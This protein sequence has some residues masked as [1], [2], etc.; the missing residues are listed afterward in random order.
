MTLDDRTPYFCLYNPEITHELE[1]SGIF[2]VHRNETA[3]TSVVAHLQ[4][5]L[6][7]VTLYYDAI[8][9]GDPNGA[10]MSSASRQ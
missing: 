6:S 2:S 3:V 5:S 10:F 4:D 9:S 8:R 1:V 7:S